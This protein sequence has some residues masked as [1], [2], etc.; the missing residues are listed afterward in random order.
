[1]VGL[2]M[3]SYFVSMLKWAKR[4]ETGSVFP[5][6]KFVIKS[7]F[8]S[9]FYLHFLFNNVWGFDFNIF[10]LRRLRSLLRV[11]NARLRCVLFCSLFCYRATE[12]QINF[13]PV[14]RNPITIRRFSSWNSFMQR[15]F[16]IELE[17]Y[18]ELYENILTYERWQKRF[19]YELNVT[20]TC[21]LVTFKKK[22]C[23]KFKRNDLLTV[24]N[25]NTLVFKETIEL[26]ILFSDLNIL[27]I[28]I[29]VKHKLTS[30]TISS[31]VQHPTLYTSCK[32]RRQRGWQVKGIIMI[33]AQPFTEN[34]RFSFLNDLEGLK[35]MKEVE[36]NFALFDIE[37]E[38]YPL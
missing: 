19:F 3:S 7:L 35:R 28:F 38:Q 5:S 33:D 12:D 36:H 13:N 2:S 24:G 23:K 22:V 4:N 17:D 15:I 11:A 10:F 27:E 9:P 18:P 16:P 25:A 26:Q 8:F 32:S 6:Q 30:G 1:M 37:I 20:N 14:W 21:R 34:K 29:N 31:E